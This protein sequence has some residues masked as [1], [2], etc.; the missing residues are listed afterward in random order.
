MQSVKKFISVSTL[1]WCSVGCQ[2]LR[3]GRY[4]APPPKLAVFWRPAFWECQWRS[5][6]DGRF[7]V[8]LLGFSWRRAQELAA[9][10]S[11]GE[12]HWAF[13]EGTN[14]Q[15][16]AAAPLRILQPGQP[17]LRP[18]TLCH[19]HPLGYSSKVLMSSLDSSGATNMST[20]IFTHVYQKSP[21]PE[22]TSSNQKSSTGYSSSHISRNLG[23]IKAHWTL[24]ALLQK[25]KFHWIVLWGTAAHNNNNPTLLRK[26]VGCPFYVSIEKIFHS[27][28]LIWMA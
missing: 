12:R 11:W 9:P 24:L 6:P 23:K 8:P 5:L 28:I 26:E 10:D 1:Q 22:E 17:S 2:C 27:K 19:W 3:Q 15:P 13:R 18:P 20:R 16:G 7:S 21:Y 4:C 25:E 14:S